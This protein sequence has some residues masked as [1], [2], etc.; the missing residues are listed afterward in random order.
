MKQKLF[1]LFNTPLEFISD[2]FVEN[3]DSCASGRRSMLFS[4]FCLN[5][6]NSLI[7]G[8]FF[9]A[10]MLA[11]GAS[12]VYIGYVTVATTFCGFSQ[13]FAPLIWEKIRKR[14]PILILTRIVYHLLNIV[15][16]GLIPL[17]HIPDSAKL[18]AF[19]VTVIIL[20]LANYIATPGI[21]AW[22][23]QSL[24][25]VKR[26]NYSTVSNLVVTII[27]IV[28]TFLASMFFDSVIADGFSIGGLT[29]TLTAIIVLRVI[30]LIF[31]ALE[32]IFYAKI[33]EYPYET[34]KENN[35]GLKLLLLPLKNKAFMMTILIPILWT[36]AGAIIGGFFNIYLLENV[37]MSY[38]LISMGGIVSTPIV[39]LMTPVWAAALKRKPWLKM[40]SIALLGYSA[41]WMTNAFITPSTL[42]C[43][44][45]CIVLGNIF[46]PCINIVN[47]NIIYLNM[48]DTNRT[49]YI[50]LNAILIQAASLLGSYVGTVFVKYTGDVSLHLF[51]FDMC[52]LQL[53]NVIAAALGVCIAAYTFAY[54]LK[55]SKG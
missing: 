47:G 21:T 34:D 12:D 4:G 32:I 10:L 6:C 36:F 55:L 18:I 51:G 15:V 17:F 3:S 8:A 11:M 37:Q 45:L 49:A 29:P 30:G 39:F 52:N 19:I 25:F 54:S 5:F 35:R 13:F 44:I 7:A 24:P 41:A 16:V 53:V 48:P 20:N 43:Y 1:H 42:F 40:L 31:A 50:S 28:T 23:M 22:H 14:K 2:A 26:L 33:K 9:T 46:Q 38:T 27:N